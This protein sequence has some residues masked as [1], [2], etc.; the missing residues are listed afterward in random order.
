MFEN[1]KNSK[2]QGDNGLG[3]AIAH[4]CAKGYTVSIPL[5]DSQEYDLIVENVNLQKVQV[6]TTAHKNKKGYYVVNMR[7]M[8]GNKKKYW[9]K[10]ID[11]TKVDILFVLTD[12]DEIYIIP[13]N[14]IKANTSITLSD[15]YKKFKL[16]V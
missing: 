15:F 5:T 10:N 6:K 3:K 12:L 11:K 4:Y 7:T 16:V 2:K 8:G 13:I 1:C 14:E 9:C